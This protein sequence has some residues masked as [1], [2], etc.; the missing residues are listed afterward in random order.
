MAGNAVIEAQNSL[1]MRCANRTVHIRTYAEMKAE[2]L[3]TKYEGLYGTFGQNTPLNP[4]NGQGNPTR[5]TT[6]PCL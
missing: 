4:N 6:L 5:N 3:E 1:W 2:G